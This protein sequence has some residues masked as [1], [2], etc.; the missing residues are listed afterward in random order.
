MYR[1][2]VREERKDI[3]IPIRNMYFSEPKFDARANSELV[4][5]P[6]A[7]CRANKLFFP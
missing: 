2:E 7:A 3:N 4:L 6:L 1:Y 5:S